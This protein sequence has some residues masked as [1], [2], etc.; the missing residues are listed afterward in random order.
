MPSSPNI[1]LLSDVPGAAGIAARRLDDTRLIP[2]TDAMTEGLPSEADV[3]VSDTETVVSLLNHFG[4]AAPPGGVT[5]LVM[6]DSLDLNRS[7]QLNASRLFDVTINDT[8]AGCPIT[9]LRAARGRQGSAARWSRYLS[10]SRVSA[11]VIERPYL[12]INGTLPGQRTPAQPVLWALSVSR[13]RMSFG[14]SPATSREQ[15]Q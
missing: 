1:T 8:S 13:T 11:E 3:A 10:H 6:V 4:S 5:R 7:D 12:A 15:L 14:S 2:T 9:T